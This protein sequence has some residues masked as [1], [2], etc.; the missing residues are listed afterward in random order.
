MMSAKFTDPDLYALGKQIY[1]LGFVMMLAAT[2]VLLGI[3]I[4]A[5]TVSKSADSIVKVFTKA[6]NPDE[7]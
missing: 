2:M 3:G 1:D 7:P 5:V 6:A 4:L